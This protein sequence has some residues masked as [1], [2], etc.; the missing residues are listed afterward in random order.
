MIINKENIVLDKQTIPFWVFFIFLLV[1]EFLLFRTFLQ[2][3]IANNFPGSW[4][5][6]SYLISSYS[7]YE[8]IM[9]LGLF[10]ALIH[11]PPAQTSFLFCIQAAVFFLFAGASRFS[12]LFINFIYFAILQFVIAKIAKSISG[13]YIAS[14]LS[15]GL[16]LAVLLPFPAAGG[17]M[18]FRIDFIAFCL[19]GIFIAAVLKSNVFYNRKWTII[20]AFIAIFLILMRYVTSVYVGGLLTSLFFIFVTLQYWQKTHHKNNQE[21]TQ[22]IKNLLLFAVIGIIVA[23]PFLWLSRY[24]IYQ[25]YIVGTVTSSEKYIRAKEFGV[26]DSLSN[27][28]FYPKMIYNSLMGLEALLLSAFLLSITLICYFVVRYPSRKKLST[29]ETEVL[30]YFNINFIFLVLCILIPVIALTLNLSKSPIVGGIVV[31]PILILV[32]LVWS[33][34]YKKIIVI[35][36][37]TN[38][39]FKLLAAVILLCGIGNWMNYYGRHSLSYG[40]DLSQVITMDKDIGNYASIM[41]WK[42]VYVSTDQ[43]VDYLS[44]PLAVVYYEHTGNLLNV[45]LSP[46]GTSIFETTPKDAINELKKSNVFITNLG[47]YQPSIYP[48][49]ESLIKIRPLLQKIASDEFIKLNDYYFNNSFYRVYVRPDFQILGL[50]DDWITNQGIW[51][52]FH[53]QVMKNISSIMLSGSINTQWIDNDLKVM[54]YDDKNKELPIHPKVVI[55]GN[56]YILYCDLPK[57]IANVPPYIHLVFSKYF[58]P[59]RLGINND[60]RKLVMQAPL[61]KIIILNA[62]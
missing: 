8:N 19:Y 54:A 47:K 37:K 34:L 41:G 57:K 56:K 58:V 46:L 48:S 4:D 39:I 24:G 50:S 44:V 10:T 53:P 11:E 49:N 33:A 60:T 6:A 36:P 2:R 17:M 40:N 62:T 12:A 18:D 61:K 31:I 35:N 43:V 9:H 55:T 45:T 14:I 27:L 30:P 16:I 26:T 5:Q 51:I 38:I 7:L 59:K 52:K 28:F 15:L 13:S 29:T 20:S 3:E 25:H 32:L 23:S 22:R 1:I 21:I 42:E